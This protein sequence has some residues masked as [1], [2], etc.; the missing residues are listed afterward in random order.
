MTALR[1]GWVRWVGER[2]EIRDADARGLQ[3]WNRATGG[4]MFGCTALHLHRSV[5]RGARVG[6]QYVDPPGGMVYGGLQLTFVWG[7]LSD[8]PVGARRP[9]ITGRTHA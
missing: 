8:V 5:P 2:Y 9:A 3:I 7:V 4:R 1:I 6:T